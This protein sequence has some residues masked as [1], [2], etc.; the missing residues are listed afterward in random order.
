VA[1]VRRR[2]PRRGL[3]TGLETLMGDRVALM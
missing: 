2:R 3:E 1:V